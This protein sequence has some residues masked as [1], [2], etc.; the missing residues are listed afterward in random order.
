MKSSA[1]FKHICIAKIQHLNSLRKP[2]KRVLGIR[3]GTSS[4]C[5]ECP[6]M[7]ALAK[8]IVIINMLK[9]LF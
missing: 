3:I 4:I 2:L 6:I 8:N 1:K 7:M 5:S 9:S